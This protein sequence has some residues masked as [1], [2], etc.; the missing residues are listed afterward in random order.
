MLAKFGAEDTVEIGEGANAGAD[1]A[2][3]EA[4]VRSG[5]VS[6]ETRAQLAMEEQNISTNLGR[7]EIIRLP[8]TCPHC[9]Y[10]GGESLTCVADIPHFKEVIIMAFDCGKV[11]QQRTMPRDCVCAVI[12]VTVVT[13]AVAAESSQPRELRLDSATASRP[14]LSERLFTVQL[15]DTPALTHPPTHSSP[16]FSPPLNHEQ[17]GY[18]SNEIKGGGGVPAKVCLLEENTTATSKESQ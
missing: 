9:G 11:I 3:E 7:R 14:R 13:V 1:G 2:G 5:W 12:A 18:R 17:C 16:S 4:P 6:D 8:S 10:D 15:T